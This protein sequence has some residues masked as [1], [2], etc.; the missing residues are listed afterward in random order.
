MVHLVNLKISFVFSYISH[1]IPQLFLH[2]DHATWN[3]SATSNGKGALD[4][5]GG[6]I[7]IS[8]CRAVIKDV[9]LLVKA[10]SQQ[11]CVH[12]KLNTL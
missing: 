5:L 1:N 12:S 3:Y 7:N 11:T 9:K 8:Y 4:S 6:T 10:V 2:Y